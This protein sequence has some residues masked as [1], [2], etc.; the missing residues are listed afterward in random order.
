MD[1]KKVDVEITLTRNDGK[2]V[3]QK[4][5]GLKDEKDIKE[6]L[7]EVEM[8]IMRALELGAF[9]DGKYPI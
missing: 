3:A 7:R 8:N 1:E 2:K 4:I 9:S 5:E 6:F